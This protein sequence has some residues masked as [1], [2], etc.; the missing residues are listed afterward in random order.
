MAAEGDLQAIERSLVALQKVIGAVGD[1][2]RRLSD[3]DSD[4]FR[5]FPPR[6]SGTFKTLEFSGVL[7]CESIHFEYLP[8]SSF[9]AGV[10]GF[11][12]GGFVGG[13]KG[14]PSDLSPSAV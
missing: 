9:G 14:C 11:A 10:Y 1:Q 13:V 8:E 12:N 5:S 4:I 3:I 6:V 7:F 2:T